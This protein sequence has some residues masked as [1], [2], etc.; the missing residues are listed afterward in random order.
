MLTGRGGSYSY[1]QPR[2][3]MAYSS[4]A[5]HAHRSGRLILVHAATAVHG[6]QQRSLTCSQVGAAHTR[7]CSH[8]SAWHTAAEPYMLTGRGGSYSYMQ[9]RQCM[10]YSGGALHA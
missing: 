2:Q 1:M 3:C 6:I 4:G 8:G 10:A 7:T 5:L 9:P